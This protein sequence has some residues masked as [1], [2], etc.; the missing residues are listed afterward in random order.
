MV[1]FLKP[2]GRQKPEMERMVANHIGD[3]ERTYP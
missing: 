2:P 1:K 3:Y